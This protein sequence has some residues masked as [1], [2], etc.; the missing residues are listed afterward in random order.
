[1]KNLQ[2]T[3]G[4]QTVRGGYL[5]FFQNTF[6]NHRDINLDTHHHRQTD[7]SQTDWPA[8]VGRNYTEAVCPGRFSHTKSV[9]PSVRLSGPIPVFP[10]PVFLNPVFRIRLSGPVSRFSESHF[11]NPTVR[12]ESR[13]PNPTVR[14]GS[15]D[16]LKR[17]T[18]A[19]D[20][21]THYVN[22]YIRWVTWLDGNGNGS[23]CSRRF[24]C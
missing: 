10:N 20:G 3:A 12:A 18:V 16:E 23:P 2:R 1:V 22:L 11:L 17:E 7:C 21:Q 5:V 6:E 24:K 9:C 14:A 4:F 8:S 15:A 13:F 19:S